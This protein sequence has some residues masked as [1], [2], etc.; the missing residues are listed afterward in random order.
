MC[1]LEGDNAAFVL[2]PVLPRQDLTV[3]A[4]TSREVAPK[5]LGGQAGEDSPSS[6]VRSRICT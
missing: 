3:I 5:E 1:T 2:R 6:R 4:K